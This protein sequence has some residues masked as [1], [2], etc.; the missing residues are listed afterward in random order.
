MVYSV[1][2][3]TSANV[4]NDFPHTTTYPVIVNRPAGI[5]T[6]CGHIN[7]RYSSLH[8]ST[9]A[10]S[11]QQTAYSY[12]HVLFD[13]T[14]R[15]LYDDQPHNVHHSTAILMHQIRIRFPDKPCKALNSY[16]ASYDN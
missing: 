3:I 2:P 16:S 1:H 12:L 8:R 14:L 7:H 9:S 11:L 13:I 4:C 6:L 10:L 5:Y 15:P